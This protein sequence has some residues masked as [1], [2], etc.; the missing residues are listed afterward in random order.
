MATPVSSRHGQKSLL[1]LGLN[2]YGLFKFSR[3]RSFGLVGLACAIG[4]QAMFAADTANAARP[5]QD[6]KGNPRYG[7]MGRVTNYDE[8]KVGTYSLPDPL[9]MNNGKPVMDAATWSKVRRETKGSGFKFFSGWWEGESD[10]VVRMEGTNELAIATESPTC[11]WTV[12]MPKPGH[13]RFHL[14]VSVN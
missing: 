8:A 9:V 4:A 14:R 7:A 2:S 6:A 5:K 3:V 12:S 11:S 1:R 10:P 13:G